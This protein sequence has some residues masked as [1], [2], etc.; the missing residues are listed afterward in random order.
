MTR[1]TV[2]RRSADPLRLWAVLSEAVL[3]RVVGSPA[4]MREQLLYLAEKAGHPKITMQVIPYSQ[5]AHPGMAAGPFQILGFPWPADPGVAYVEHRAG[6]LYLEGA[7]EIHAHN[8]AFE[9]LVALALSPDE[10]A[11]MVREIAEEYA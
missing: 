5:G 3:R 6:A 9:H 4:T 7:H 8:V 1:Q 10:S 11:E 2:L